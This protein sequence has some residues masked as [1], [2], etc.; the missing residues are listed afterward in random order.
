M[1]KTPLNQRTVTLKLKRSYVVDLLIACASCSEKQQSNEFGDKWDYLHEVI[2][3]QLDA[4]D[5]K[6]EDVL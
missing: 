4:F 3:Q 1:F 2:R 5:K 6:Q